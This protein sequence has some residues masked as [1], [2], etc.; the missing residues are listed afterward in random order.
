VFENKKIA[1]TNA[2][3]DPP[4]IAALILILFFLTFE[5]TF[6]FFML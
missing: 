6:S 1:T 4:R 3:Y 2:T 5:L